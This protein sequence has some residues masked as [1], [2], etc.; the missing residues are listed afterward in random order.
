MSAPAAE[1]AEADATLFCIVCLC[2]LLLVFVLV[3]MW[4]NDAWHRNRYVELV[5]K[6]IL[7][8]QRVD[9]KDCNTDQQ[10]SRVDAAEKR[11]IRHAK[12]ATPAKRLQAELLAK[13]RNHTLLICAGLGV[14][15]IP[16]CNRPT[17]F[18]SASTED[19]HAVRC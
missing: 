14:S 12:N 5:R 9:K 17:R 4:R 8:K 2:A 6:A 16:A 19:P 7:L 10:R 1:P 13:A 15:W 11:A 3:F 18:A